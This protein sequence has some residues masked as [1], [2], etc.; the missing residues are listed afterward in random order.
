M[1]IL[2]NEAVADPSKV[3]DYLFFEFLLNRTNTFWN[4]LILIALFFFKKKKDWKRSKAKCLGE[5]KITLTK[6]CR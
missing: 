3:I 4:F 5:I 6:K 1:R 2:G